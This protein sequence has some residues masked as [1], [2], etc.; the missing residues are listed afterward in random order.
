MEKE[1]G[2]GRQGEQELDRENERRPK[3]G[4]ENTMN[5]TGPVGIH[6][7]LVTVLPLRH[8]TSYSDR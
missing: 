6:R 5:Q 7:M 2:G 8:K 4:K 3:R 1:K